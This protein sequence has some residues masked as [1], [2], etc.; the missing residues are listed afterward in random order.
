MKTIE[1]TAQTTAANLFGVK[2]NAAISA[3][4]LT[5]DE[6][7][8][9]IEGN[10]ELIEAIE[11]TA[12]DSGTLDPQQVLDAV[13]S[14][15]KA[16][17]AEIKNAGKNGNPVVT[18]NNRTYSFAKEQAPAKEQTRVFV[19]TECRNYGEIR[20]SRTANGSNYRPVNIGGYYLINNQD[21]SISTHPDNIL[22]NSALVSKFIKDYDINSNET[23]DLTQD[24]KSLAFNVVTEGRIAGVT[25]YLETAP[26]A[27]QA[28]KGKDPKDVVRSSNAAGQST[29]LCYH[30]ISNEFA[31]R[32]LGTKITDSHL[33]MLTKNVERV[34]EARLKA[35]EDTA[36]DKELAEVNTKKEIAAIEAKENA[37]AKAIEL[38]INAVVG[39]AAIL[40]EH[41]IDMQ[42]LLIAAL[43][44]K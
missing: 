19:M 17:K 8:G 35:I 41:K 11:A 39:Q 15:L 33:T 1:I 26:E 20:K 16:V 9:A 22:T 7:Y 37:S 21:G 24:G 29:V 40:A 14:Y 6:L 13:N 10:D 42:A 2:D 23:L 36:K 32:R 31:F 25:T 5:P 28:A 4:C 43:T 3:L 44:N 12:D 30:T 27:V 18:V 38:K 34:A